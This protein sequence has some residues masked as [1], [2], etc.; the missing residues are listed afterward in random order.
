MESKQWSIFPASSSF[1]GLFRS[2]F[3]LDLLALKFFSDFNQQA[4]EQRD[5]HYTYL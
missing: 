4:F 1:W 3:Y 5:C 2:L